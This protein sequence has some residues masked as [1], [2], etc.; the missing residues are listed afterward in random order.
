MDI[1]VTEQ[2]TR[3]RSRLRRQQLR[4]IFEEFDGKLMKLDREARVEKYRIMAQSPFSFY[5]GSAYLFY[6]DVTQEWFPFHTTAGRPTWIQGDLHFENFGAF[7]TRTGGIQYD[8]NDFD[9]GY[10]GS[11][12]Y[13]L[14]RMAVS[15]ALV[16]DMKG[17]SAE[18]QEKLV[19]IYIKAYSKQIRRFAKGEDDPASFL[20][21]EE[22]AKG[23][24]KRL[25]R[26][27]H[28]RQEGHLLEKIT[29]V[30]LDSTRQFQDTDE[31]VEP[32]PEEREQLLA[33]WPGYVESIADHSRWTPEHY[34]IKDIAVKRGSGTASIGLNRYYVLIEADAAVEGEGP[35]DIVLEVK[36]V[37]VPVPAYFMPFSESFW[38]AFGHQGKRVVQTQ[39]AMHHA[40]DP[41]LG[42]LT[43]GGRDY[44]VRE[45][46]P[47]KKRLRLDSLEAAAD[48]GS[49]L[50]TMGRITAK[51]H[52]RA[53]KDLEDG[54]LSYHSEREILYAM[55][56]DEESFCHY[57]AGWALSYADVVKEDYRLFMEWS[58]RRRAQK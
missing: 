35:E 23:P 52:A 53:D 6:F 57:V 11:Y 56:P 25:L 38:G 7:R 34:T 8:V 37:R 32:T 33:A 28:K 51:I 10:L 15:I 36:E 19:H 9:E 29:A 2:V 14:L 12:L 27:L 44:Y 55:G 16:G 43:I 26:K 54:M 20:M 1:R 41:Y 22:R 49:V 40:A 47:Y 48:L 13:D 4:A 3:T 58:Q 30:M 50:K 17:M 42:C 31:L 45:R 5:R 24:V 46:S 18:E 21:N 39:Q